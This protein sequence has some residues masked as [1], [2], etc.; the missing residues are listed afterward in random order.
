MILTV[1]IFIY[2]ALLTERGQVGRFM[3]AQKKWT[4]QADQSIW[5]KGGGELAK[6]LPGSQN[7]RSAML[8]QVAVVLTTT[9]GAVQHDGISQRRLVW[10]K[11]RA[12]VNDYQLTMPDRYLPTLLQYSQRSLHPV[13]VIAYRTRAVF[14][15]VIT[16]DITVVIVTRT[17]IKARV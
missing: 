12:H 2:L 3:T 11:L 8:K 15:Y 14:L 10:L 13:S 1:D 5:D 4:G 6:W 16:H 9:L 7:R 17:L